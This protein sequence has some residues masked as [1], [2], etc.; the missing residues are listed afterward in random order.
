M[1]DKLTEVY[2]VTLSDLSDAQFTV[3]TTRAI[4]ELKFFPRVAELRELSGIGKREEQEDVE[5]NAAFHAVIHSL[6]RRGIDAGIRHLP[7]RTQYA[8]RQC[9]G[10]FQFNTRLQ[11]QYG[12]DENPSHMESRSPIFL[13]RDF[14][15]AYKSFDLHKAMLPQLTEKGLLALPQPVRAALGNASRPA[16]SEP[17]RAESA[18][19]KPSQVIKPMPAAR[20]PK[21]EAEICD[22]REMLRQQ[23]KAFVESRSKGAPPEMAQVK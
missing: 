1:D 15:T 18:G 7:E 21:S 10:L 22:S 5:A 17:K 23:A 2:L 3:A 14:V 8:V 9:G 12:D 13:Q 11:V 4:R 19:T 16:S 20:R 6:E